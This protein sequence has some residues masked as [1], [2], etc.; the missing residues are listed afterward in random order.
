M[1]NSFTR[2]VSRILIV[3]MIVL[4]FNVHAGLIGTD[5]IVSAAQAQAARDKVLTLVDRADVARQLQAFGLTPE[6]AKDRVNALTD[7]EIAQLAGQIESVPA[8]A[9]G[10]GWVLVILIVVLIWWLAKK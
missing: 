2:L 6:T 9:N 8:G 5:T 10:A 3:C 1:S 7:S 4:P